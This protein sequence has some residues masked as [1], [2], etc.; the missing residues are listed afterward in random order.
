MTVSP[1]G[2]PVPETKKRPN[3]SFCSTRMFQRA[4]QAVESAFSCAKRPAS[5]AGLGC[6]HLV[7]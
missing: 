3:A 2:T 1:A 6:V 5:T 7:S 4:M